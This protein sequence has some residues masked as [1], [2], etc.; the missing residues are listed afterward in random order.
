M[1]ISLVLMTT[2]SK[3]GTIF[4]LDIFFFFEVV[5][6]KSVN[7][8]NGLMRTNCGALL[9]SWTLASPCLKMGDT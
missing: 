6:K 7:V 8:E 5:E 4:L 3:L 1:S 2:C 9:H